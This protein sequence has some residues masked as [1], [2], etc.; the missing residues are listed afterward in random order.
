MAARALRWLLVAY[1]L[2]AVGVALQR[3]LLSHE[4]NFL[5]LRAAFE[6]L[7]AGQDLYAAYPAV[8]A[9]FFKYSPTFAFLFAPFAL[10]PLVPGYVLWALT[11]A[12]TVHAS[13]SRL[14]APREAALALL[15]SWLA[16]VGDMQRAQSNALCAGLI[17][18]AW[19]ALERRRQV[20]AAAAIA[21]GT[22]IK[23][24][25]LAALAGAAFH[26][27]K[28]RFGALFSL[29]MLLAVALP[30]LVVSPDSLA[31]QYRSWMAIEARD[32]APLTGIASGGADLYAGLMGLFRVWGGVQWPS[33]PT[34]LV[35]TIV[36]L[37][38]IAWNRVRPRPDAFFRVQFLGSLLVFC[39]L[40]NHQAESPSYSIAIVGTAIWFAASERA[41]WRTALMAASF[42]IINLGSTDLMPRAW[43]RAYYVP[44][45]LKTVPLLPVWL[46]MQA[47]LLG[48]IP[49]RGASQ[50]GE[51]D[52]RGARAA[53]PLPD[54]G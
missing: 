36:L 47:E 6:H 16:V 20:G 11:C 7:L 34:Q 40:F 54:R 21:V 46:A 28:R 52:E 30:L 45:L 41:W 13:V 53:E 1:V 4:N 49:N 51:A 44:Y 32:A 38:P 2:S 39:V 8:H 48:L 14:L 42:I 31:A 33:W 27:R 24:F 19:V 3:T 25:P 10:L 17:V 37:A 12:V 35:G 22:L 18:L 23:L 43:Y 50:V 9:D 15:L 5:I 29:A 26:P